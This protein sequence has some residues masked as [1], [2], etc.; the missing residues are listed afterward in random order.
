MIGIYKF[1]NKY[2]RK[3]YIGQSKNIKARYYNHFNCAKHLDTYFYRALRKYGK[4]GFDFEVIMECPIENLDYW[5]KF[6]IKYYGSNIHDY[7][8]NEYEGG[9]GLTKWTPELRKKMSDSTKKRFEKE[10]ERLKCSIAAKKRYEDPNEREKVRQEQYKRLQNTE[11]KEFLKQI[12]INGNNKWKDKLNKLTIKEIEDLHIKRS[13][14]CKK[15]WAKLDE[16]TRK[17]YAENN[18]QAQLKKNA[19]PNYI[20]PTRGKHKVW[21]DDTHTKYHYEK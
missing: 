12:G 11:Y 15:G 5:E 1:T 3:V 8:Y 13:N 16:N 21:D 10:E 2:N 19:D 6:Y 20:H 4:E 17:Q 9:T 14:G 7:G 18:R